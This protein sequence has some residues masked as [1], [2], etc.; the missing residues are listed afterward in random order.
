[1]TGSDDT[2]SAVAAWAARFEW[3]K[4]TSKWRLWLFLILCL[5]LGTLGALAI[6]YGNPGTESVILQAPP[7]FISVYTSQPNVSLHFQVRVSVYPG[8]GRS[9]SLS[10]AIDPGSHFT[11]GQILIVS[12]VR[13]VECSGCR[14]LS[15]RN[16]DPSL[17][18]PNLVYGLIRVISNRTHRTTIIDAERGYG[19]GYFERVPPVTEQTHAHYFIHM[20]V[21]GYNEPFGLPN[22]GGSA[23]LISEG[24]KSK[25]SSAL[26]V[27]DLRLFPGLKNKTNQ[28]SRYLNPSNYKSSPGLFPLRA[29]WEPL[30]FASTEIL[31]GLPNQ[32]RNDHIDSDVPTSGHFVQEPF[33]RSLGL[34]WNGD[35]GETEA[36]L[37]ATDP[38]A[39]QIEANYDFL[40][41]VAFAIA[42]AAFIAFIQELPRGRP[43]RLK[44]R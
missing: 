2:E 8:L 41:G 42:A 6:S 1:V 21:I 10:V 16:A 15:I 31:D 5:L 12:S 34:E 38:D 24:K 17:G 32:L 20:P 26:E 14:R 30:S 35:D 4:A 44:L 27:S 37:A 39:A 9:E 7:Q 11:S 25:R 33:G 36:S 13:G 18:E 23:E 3:S 29:F 40:S 43:R 19:V 28:A 22:Q